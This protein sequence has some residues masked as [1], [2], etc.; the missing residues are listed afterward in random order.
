MDNTGN[1]LCHEIN[2]KIVRKIKITF[3]LSKTFLFFLEQKHIFFYSWKSG[4]YN[5]SEFSCLS[6]IFSEAD[7]KGVDMPWHC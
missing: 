1:D 5:S 2:L 6:I 7:N 4:F 3:L